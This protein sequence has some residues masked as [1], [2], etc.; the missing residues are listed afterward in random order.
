MSHWDG[1]TYQTGHQLH[2]DLPQEPISVWLLATIVFIRNL[3]AILLELLELQQIC[4][5]LEYCIDFCLSIGCFYKERILEAC[6]LCQSPV[7][8]YHPFPFISQAGSLY[9]QAVA[10]GYFLK[11]VPII[12]VPGFSCFRWLSVSF[13]EVLTLIVTLLFYLSDLLSSPSWVLGYVHPLLFFQFDLL[14]CFWSLLQTGLAARFL[15]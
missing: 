10:F 11:C 6:M 9:D 4:P 8:I 5:V 2:A 13:Q 1:S 14:T 7:I 3:G 15:Q 12:G